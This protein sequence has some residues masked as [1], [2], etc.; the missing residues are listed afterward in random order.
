MESMM[1]FSLLLCFVTSCAVSVALTRSVRE[2]ALAK[3]IVTAPEL[4]RHVHTEAVPRLGGVAIYFSVML[5]LAVSVAG[6][7]WLGMARLFSIR[8]M[9]GLMGP[10]AIVFLLGLYDDLRGADAYLKFGVQTLAACLLYFSG[11]GVERIDLFSRSHALGMGVGLPITVFW[12]LLV[13]NAFNLIDGLD[14]LAAGSAFFSTM[15]MFVISLLRGNFVVS[16]ITITLAGAMLGFLRF[17]FNPATIFLG[18]SGSLFVGFVLS[19]VALAGSQKAT[20]IVAVTIPV[21]AFGLP[22]LDVALAVVRRYLGGRP[23]FRGDNDHIHHKLL[24]RGFSQRGA[25]LTLYGVT[26][27]FGLLSLALLHGEKLL[28][29][30]LVVIGFGVFWGIHQLRYIEF[31]ELGELMQH[32]VMRRKIMANNVN[33]RRA[34]E[35]LASCKDREGLCRI[36]QQTFEPLGFDGFYLDSFEGARP[37]EASIGPLRSDAKGKLLYRW[38]VEDGV[39]P[40]WELRLQLPSEGSRPVAYLCLFQVEED[41]PLLFD[42]RVLTNGLRTSISDAVQR[43]ISQPNVTGDRAQAAGQD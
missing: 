17:N 8:G 29:M 12:V 26:A 24:K 3:G 2:K 27:A 15:A 38:S 35:V 25:V 1:I 41:R 40:V 42:L 28:A 36:L 11:Y 32:A 10:A 13:T 14:G 6:A 20:T 43:T 31:S 39:D 19:A 21:I 23:L 37:P 34:T 7:E 5:V 33:V 30:I 9:M 22:I 18:D 4:D 16:I